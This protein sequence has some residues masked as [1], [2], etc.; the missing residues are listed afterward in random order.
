M[1]KI[2][3]DINTLRNKIKQLKGEVDKTVHMDHNQRR[4]AVSLIRAK[5]ADL[6]RY[7]ENI[8]VDTTATIGTN[9]EVK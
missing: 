7:V 8:G 3:I 1:I 6:E 9:E 2:N 5:I 4:D